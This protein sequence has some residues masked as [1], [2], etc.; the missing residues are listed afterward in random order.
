MNLQETKCTNKYGNRAFSHVG[1]KLW[2]L[3]QKDI[4]N[5]HDTAMF[6]KM[7]KSRF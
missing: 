1:P 2:N 7:L 3:L 4:R 5:E 6:K